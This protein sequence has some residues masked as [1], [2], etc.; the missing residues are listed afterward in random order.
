MDKFKLL[1][2]ICFFPAVSGNE[3]ALA[4]FL[5]QQLTPVSDKILVDQIG[6]LICCKDNGYKKIAA[7]A[8][9]DKVGFMIAKDGKK[10]EAVGLTAEVEAKL[11]LNKKIDAVVDG[12]YISYQPNF[13][14]KKDW[15]YS[16]GL[17]N[18]LGIVAAIEWFKQIK[19]G[20]LALTV[21]EEMK[22]CGAMM[23]AKKIKPKQALIIDTTYADDPKSVVKHGGGVSF[24]LKDDF[25][26]DKTMFNKAVKI[27]QQSKLNYQIEILTSG[28]SDIAGIYQGYGWLPHL[29]MGIPISNMHTYKEKVFI[30]DWLTAINFLKNYS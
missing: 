3:T 8:H 22:F 9:M 13:C 15:I 23:A 6:N 24:C 17:D 14:R 5:Y 21:Q 18:A 11:P 30:E 26:S 12:Y 20:S 2:T 27:C 19:A 28:N 7:F 4:R 25:L 10:P 29:F 1:E 16:Q